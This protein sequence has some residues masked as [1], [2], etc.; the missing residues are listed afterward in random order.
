MY[1]L[2]NVTK[3]L[4]NSNITYE[5]EHN[6]NET[7]KALDECALKHGA[8]ES[9]KETTSEPLVRVSSYI[10]DIHALDSAPSC[11]SVI[12]CFPL[13]SFVNYLCTYRFLSYARVRGTSYKRF[14]HIHTINIIFKYP[15]F[16]VIFFK[17]NITDI[18]LIFIPIK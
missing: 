3:G 15:T 16:N 1:V 9:A 10:R 5:Q 8:I 7:P 4:F 17:R 2:I 11:D 6:H 18:G 13:I 14:K 12:I